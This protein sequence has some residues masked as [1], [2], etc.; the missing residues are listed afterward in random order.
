MLGGQSP[1][2]EQTVETISVK[3]YIV[4]R[5]ALP[6]NTVAEFTRLLFAARQ[7]LGSEYPVLAK[8]EKPDTDRDAAI[9]A[10][11][12]A[13]AFLDNIRKPLR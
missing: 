8:I 5:S 1:L 9:P 10:H 12:G 3:H 2:P 4:G 11:P 6:E 7:A 13:A